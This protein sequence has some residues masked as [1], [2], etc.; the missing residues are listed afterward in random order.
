MTCHGM[1]L[2]S[3][4]LIQR[5]S[6]SLPA[7]RVDV[8]EGASERRRR[9]PAACRQAALLSQSKALEAAVQDGASRRRLR[10]ALPPDV[11][12]GTLFVFVF[13]SLFFVF[14]FSFS[15]SFIFFTMAPAWLRLR[16]ASLFSPSFTSSC[17]LSAAE[18]AAAAP[19]APS[20]RS[21]NRALARSAPPEPPRNSPR[22][23]A[24]ATRVTVPRQITR[25]P[26]TRA[27]KFFE[28]TNAGAGRT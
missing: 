10:F 2:Q 25:L 19:A 1:S 11:A 26:L 18:A 12:A 16:R 23:S 27:T 20:A 22:P 14:G 8:P 7:G 4:S 13:G 24:R 3:C 9:L 15:F 6:S 21:L 5:G 28:E 17:R